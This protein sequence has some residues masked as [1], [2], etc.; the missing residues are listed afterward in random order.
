MVSS[1]VPSAC[2]PAVRLPALAAGLPAGLRRGAHVLRSRFPLLDQLGRFALVGGTSSAVNA[3]VYLVLRLVLGAL[4]A[5]LVALLISTAVSTE[6]H[7]RFTFD[8]AQR[9]PWRIWVQDAGT[10]A[11]YAV[12]SSAVLLVVGALV[13]DPSSLLESAAITL[14]SVLGGLI[15]FGVLKA[16]VFRAR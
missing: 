10:V 8:G 11:F 2:P 12:Y 3:V 16:W 15:R 5:N 9:R 7:R 1:V 6:L 4:S 14:A 13:E